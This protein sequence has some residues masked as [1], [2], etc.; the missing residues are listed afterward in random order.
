MSGAD[1]RSS[2]FERLA[3]IS[4]VSIFVNRSTRSDRRGERRGCGSPCLTKHRLALQTCLLLLPRITI[5]LGA[6]IF[7]WIVCKL[8][9]CGLSRKTMLTRG[10]ATE[11]WTWRRMLIQPT[12]WAVR[13]ILLS[14]GYK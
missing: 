11:A 4:D 5:F 3:P 1:V 6:L 9:T 7:A 8:G 12:V 10:A 13:V 14:F 2:P